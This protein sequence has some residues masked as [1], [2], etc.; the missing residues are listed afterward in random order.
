MRIFDSTSSY[1]LETSREK[2]ESLASN[3]G[4]GVENVGTFHFGNEKIRS[5]THN[6]SE[7]VVR[8][9]PSLDDLTI[10]SSEIKQL[11]TALN[12]ALTKSGSIS[13]EEFPSKME[14]EISCD[15]ET[16]RVNVNS[17]IDLKTVQLGDLGSHGEY[18]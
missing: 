5:R 4:I 17:P 16:G 6:K 14:S 8:I 9:S 1:I 18:R 10:K 2:I 3:F 12:D 15:E 7:Y 11:K 13:H